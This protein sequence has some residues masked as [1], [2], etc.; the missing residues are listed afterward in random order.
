MARTT[1]YLAVLFI[2]LLV[3][4]NAGELL[5]ADKCPDDPNIPCI[6]FPPAKNQIYNFIDAIVVSYTSPWAGGVNI[7]LNCW[8]SANHADPSTEFVHLV[9]DDLFCSNCASRVPSF[10][11]AR[12]PTPNL[13]LMHI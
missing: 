10:P 1:A 4:A 12:Y 3:S 5:T 2:E 13:S 7:S 8:P 11:C 6:L 9:N